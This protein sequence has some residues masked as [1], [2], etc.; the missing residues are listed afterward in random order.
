M[1]LLTGEDFQHTPGKPLWKV[2][3]TLIIII[4]VLGFCVG[5]TIFYMLPTCTCVL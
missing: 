4:S 2:K 3:R 1:A 5:V